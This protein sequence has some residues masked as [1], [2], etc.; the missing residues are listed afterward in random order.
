MFLNSAA[1]WLTSNGRNFSLMLTDAE[2]VSH[3]TCGKS[4][5]WKNGTIQTTSKVICRVNR[6][7]FNS[8]R[9]SSLPETSVFINHRTLQTHIGKT[10]LREAYCNRREFAT[11]RFGQLSPHSLV[12]A[13]GS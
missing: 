1:I 7:H 3:R 6:K 11:K 9:G 13:T 5:G 10:G 8:W 2:L 12:N 4:C